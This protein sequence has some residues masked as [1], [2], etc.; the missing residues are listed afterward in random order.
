MIAGVHDGQSKTHLTVRV[1][2]RCFLSPN[3]KSLS[4]IYDEYRWNGVC[5]VFKSS[6]LKLAVD[7]PISQLSTQQF[8]KLT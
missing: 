5:D 4:S 1:K 7:A 3:Y 8:A 2:V 6:R